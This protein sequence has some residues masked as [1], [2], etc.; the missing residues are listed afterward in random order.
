MKQPSL[1]LKQ[2]RARYYGADRIAEDGVVLY[3]P[4]KMT[5]ERYRF[6]GANIDTPY[7]IDVSDLTNPQVRSAVYDEGVIAGRVSEQLALTL[8]ESRG[9]PD[10]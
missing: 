10:A 4:A 3:N 7:T 6:R 5:V 1:I 9:E 8:R 2:V